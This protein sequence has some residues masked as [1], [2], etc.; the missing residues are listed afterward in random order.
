MA[1]STNSARMVGGSV[2]LLLGPNFFSRPQDTKV[3][4][5]CAGNP[6]KLATLD[7]APVNQGPRSCD[8]R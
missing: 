7:E 8:P 3:S 2:G 5:E 4:Q 1:V 6:G